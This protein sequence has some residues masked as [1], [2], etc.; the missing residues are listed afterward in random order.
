MS[1]LSF[2]R[3][4]NAKDL[5]DTDIPQ[6]SVIALGTFD[7]VHLAHRK[8]LRCAKELR[9]QQ[10]PNASHAVLCFAEPPS[11]FLSSVPIPH[12]YTL[13][14]KTEAFREEGLDHIFIV[15]F[16]QIRELSPERFVNEILIGLLHCCGAVCG[17]N[18]RFGKDGKGN[19]NVLA[20]LLNHAV[21]TLPEVLFNGS[22][23]SSTRIR[24]LLA[25][26]E[27]EQV[28]SLLTKP[29]EL[30]AP[31]LH[32]K[33]LGRKLGFPTVN[34]AFPQN[35]QVPARGVYVTL[36]T[37]EKGERYPAISNVGMHPTVDREAEINCET[38]LLD[39]EGDLYGQE[40]RVSF[41]SYIRPEMRFSGVE[42]LQ[43][44][45]QSDIQAARNYFQD[46]IK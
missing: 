22:T 4:L 25:Q 42:E 2:I 6:A 18:Y 46:Q 34:Q 30:V 13:A 23:V 11:D 33:A 31:V 41:L 5:R 28:A 43:K 9:D 3:C 39:Y 19:A 15:D 20:S 29:Y 1:S 7:G 17:F 36:C 8:L 37:T 38:Y 44:Q 35:A 24:S 26:G 16:Q 12:I 40:V 45:V 27:M 10:F 14:Q 32:G 21:L